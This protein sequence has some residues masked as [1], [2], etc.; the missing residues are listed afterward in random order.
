MGAHPCYRVA[1]PFGEEWVES[2]D[3]TKLTDQPGFTGHVKDTSTGLTSMQARYYDP[4]IGRFLS[5]D[6]VQFS[7]ARTDMFGRYAYAANDPVNKLDPDGRAWGLASKVLKVAIKGGDIGATFAGAAADLKTIRSG[8]TVS[9]RALAVASLATE[10]F[11]PV[12]ARDAKAG[13]K[14]AGGAYK[15]LTGSGK[16]VAVSS[17]PRSLCFSALK[18]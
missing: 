9:A 13:A 10:V 7:P 5:T 3:L 14:F 2:G 11:S 1:S 12:S 6:P 8:T 17:L 16:R 18:R 15:K 4:V